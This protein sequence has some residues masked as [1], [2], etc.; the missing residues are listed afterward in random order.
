MNYHFGVGFNQEKGIYI[1]DEQKRYNFKGS[2]DAK[3]NKVISAVS[4]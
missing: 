2:V 4:A 3:I 1:G